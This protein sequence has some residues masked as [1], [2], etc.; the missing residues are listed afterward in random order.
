MKTLLAN[1]VI[2]I[3][4][5]MD[6]GKKKK[7]TKIYIFNADHHPKYLFQSFF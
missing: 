6:Y 2:P 4:H 1:G 3:K 7:K 5:D